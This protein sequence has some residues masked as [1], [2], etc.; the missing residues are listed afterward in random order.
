MSTLHQRAVVFKHVEGDAVYKLSD[1]V[2]FGEDD[3][4]ERLD[5]ISYAA[6]YGYTFGFLPYSIGGVLLEEMQYD[7]GSIM[8]WSGTD[9]KFAAAIPNG[10][11]AALRGRKFKMFLVVNGYDEFDPEPHEVTVVLQ[12]RTAKRYD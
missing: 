11:A 4:L 7:Y 6:T 1:D 2:Q 10:L 5:I 9:D 8:Q 12:I 3:M